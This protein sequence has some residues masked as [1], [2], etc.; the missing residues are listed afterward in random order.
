MSNKFLS[1]TGT[2]IASFTIPIVQTITIAKTPVEIG[3]TAKAIT[4]SILDNGGQGSG[5]IIQRQGDIYT[6]LTAAHALREQSNYKI[7]APD[8]R[9]YQI[10]NNSIRFAPDNIDLAIVK[11]RST[12]PYST[13]KLGNSNINTLTLGTDLYV[14]GFP[15]V[16]Q[17]IT[18]PTIVWREGKVSANYTQKIKNGYSLIYSNDTLRGMSGGPV[19]NNDGELVAIHGRGEAIENGNLGRF[20]S[21]VPIHH[22]IT[23]A[24]GM[25]VNLDRSVAAIPKK[26]IPINRY[27]LMLHRLPQSNQLCFK[28]E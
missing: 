1:L 15:S 9:Q 28:K 27:R 10:L 14:A 16:N 25:G 20:N 2:M 6:V 23:V 12:T 18:K 22:F 26:T 5:V 11:F 21:G 13:A 4:V 3:E 17:V 8:D 24:S 19:F 7:I